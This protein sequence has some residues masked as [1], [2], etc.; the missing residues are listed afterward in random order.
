[1]RTTGAAATAAILL[2]AGACQ[3]TPPKPQTPI[4]RTLGALE[5][6][7]VKAYEEGRFEE[8][9]R[10][11]GES[12]ALTKSTDNLQGLANAFNNLAAVKREMGDL[13]GALEALIRA[14]ALNEAL[15]LQRAA[16]INLANVA[17]VEIERRSG[18]LARARDANRQAEAI[19][20][21][22]DDDAGRV[23]TRNNEGRILLKSG[24][25]G[26][27]RRAFEE[28]LEMTG[29]G[30]AARLRTVVLSNL[31]RIDE[32][33]GDLGRALERY[34]TALEADREMEIFTGVARDLEAM[35]RVQ[36]KLGSRAE[37]V[38][39]LRR[40]LDVVLLRIRWM[41]WI[42]AARDRLETL[43]RSLGRD[44]EAEEVR[45][46]VVEELERAKKEEERRKVAT[47][48][49]PIGDVIPGEK[50]K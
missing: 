34:R 30:D 9:M 17:A 8:A 24:N 33:S 31:G 49:P 32:E 23:L 20:A 42:E 36:V 44:K 22:L 10:L 46:H 39:T 29:E 5:E 19:F 37:A 18:S 4:Q 40:A 38:D 3:T 13:D 48:E 16:A 14:Q 7:G 2:W 41:P 1:M 26:E 47:R 12:E 35:A 45:K 15:G 28:A 27:A 25:L 6:Q 11:F 50:I 43:L 21:G